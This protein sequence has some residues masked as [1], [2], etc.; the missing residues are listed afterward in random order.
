MGAQRID[1]ITETPVVGRWYLVRALHYDR[2]RKGAM[3]WPI[4]GPKHTDV[5]F[6]NFDIEHY[7][8]DVRFLTQRHLRQIGTHYVAGEF[9]YAFSQPCQPV[10][11]AWNSDTK[12]YDRRPMPTPTLTRMQCRRTT[13]EYPFADRKPVAEIN[14][15][16]QGATAKLTERGWICPH[17][18]V[19][20]GNQIPDAHGVITCPLHGLRIDAETGRCV[21]P[22]SDS[23]SR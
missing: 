1:R 20:L 6:F 11:E 9:G 18:K 16:Y 5:E 17:R 2:F 3:A 10:T 19:A 21:G 15:K 8:L 14:A 22:V 23:A 4:T 12:K 13:V 7:H